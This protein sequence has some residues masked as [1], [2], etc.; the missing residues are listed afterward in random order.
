[1]TTNK[2][3]LSVKP[4]VQPTWWREHFTPWLDGYYLIEHK[5]THLLFI[6]FRHSTLQAGYDTLTRLLEDISSAKPKTVLLLADLREADLRAELVLEWQEQSGAIESKCLRI[7]L[8]GT[9]GLPG[10][11]VKRISKIAGLA[12]LRLGGKVQIFDEVGSALNWL[13]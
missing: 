11:T 2:L 1:M 3:A 8:V 7:A 5:Q 13:V 9:H 12:H 10:N 4:F 6:T